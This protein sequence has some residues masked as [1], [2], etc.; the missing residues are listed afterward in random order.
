M[1]IL[2]TTTASLEEMDAPV[3]LRQAPAPMVVLSFTDSDL[4]GLAAAWDAERDVLPALRL[5]SLRE[6]RHP[7]SVDFWVDV[8]WRF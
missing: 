1:H 8:F 5:V 3:D 4:S 6:L 2:T 7:M